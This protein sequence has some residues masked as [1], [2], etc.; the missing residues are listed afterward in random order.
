[1]R[2][3]GMT[4]RLGGPELFDE[5]TERYGEPADAPKP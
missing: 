1:M 2:L 3:N 4:T 5:Y